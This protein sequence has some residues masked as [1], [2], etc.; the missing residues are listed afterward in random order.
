MW[1]YE[2]V[3]NLNKEMVEAGTKLNTEVE[4]VKA[5]MQTLEA[6]LNEKEY[7][8]SNNYEKNNKII[9]DILNF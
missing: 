1:D 8:I 7:M 4:N 2:N 9:K 5:D 6:K 3:K